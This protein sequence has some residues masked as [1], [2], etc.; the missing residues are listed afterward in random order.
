MAKRADSGKQAEEMLR[1]FGGKVDKPVGKSG[2]T[3]NKTGTG[4]N[5]VYMLLG[6][7]YEVALSVV[8]EILYREEVAREAYEAKQWRGG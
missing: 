4:K 3:I 2:T 8:T 5:A 1:D 7:P 6:I